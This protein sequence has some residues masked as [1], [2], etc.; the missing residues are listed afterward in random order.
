[1]YL[2][3]TTAQCNAEVK[4]PQSVTDINSER[5]WKFTMSKGEGS[6]AVSGGIERQKDAA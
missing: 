4:R 3:I 2:L 5:R 6:V 1:M